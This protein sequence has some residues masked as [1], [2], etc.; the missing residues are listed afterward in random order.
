M[1]LVRRHVNGHY[2]TRVQYL[3]CAQVSNERSQN[4]VAIIW[5]YAS[6]IQRVILTPSRRH[7]AQLSK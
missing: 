5:Q 3:Q 2:S 7:P 4:A 6:P 1:H